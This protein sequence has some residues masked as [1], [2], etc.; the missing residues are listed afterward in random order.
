M[1]IKSLI[2]ALF[3]LLHLTVVNPPL[4]T[5]ERGQRIGEEM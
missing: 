1:K 3:V 4:Y 2:V 5:S